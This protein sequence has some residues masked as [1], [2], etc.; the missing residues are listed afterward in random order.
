ML[1]SILAKSVQPVCVICD[2]SE[3]RGL[4]MGDDIQ[5]KRVAKVSLL[6]VGRTN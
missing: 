6:T 4:Q 2:L 1:L 5:T 3:N